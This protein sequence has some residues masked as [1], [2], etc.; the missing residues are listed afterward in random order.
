ME[1]THSKR[2]NPANVR[3]KESL[4]GFRGCSE[5]NSRRAQGVRRQRTFDVSPPFDEFR[6]ARKLELQF[7][8][9]TSL[10]SSFVHKLTNRNVFQ[11]DTQRFEVREFRCICAARNRTR[12]D[13]T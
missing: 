7:F 12:N 6:S 2:C 8:S 9:E 10:D 1:R 4:Q 11:R 5:K 13:L 3:S